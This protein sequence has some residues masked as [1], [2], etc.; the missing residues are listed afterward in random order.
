MPLV[1]L[2]G[3]TAGPT[4]TFT[5]GPAHEAEFSVTFQNVSD[6]VNLDVGIRV[7]HAEC[8]PRCEL[9]RVLCALPPCGVVVLLMLYDLLYCADD[10]QPG[11][12]IQSFGDLAAAVGVPEGALRAAWDA[13]NATWD[14]PDS[15]SLYKVAH[16][17]ASLGLLAPAV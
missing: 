11:D 9:T 17:A 13:A 5:A 16:M 15:S 4:L 7:S 10:A 8:A 14:A 3:E 2:W 6:V 12:L 1:K